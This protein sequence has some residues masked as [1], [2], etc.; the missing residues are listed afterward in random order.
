[1]QNLTEGFVDTAYPILSPLHWR[2]FAGFVVVTFLAV[3]IFHRN[4][5]GYPCPDG[6]GKNWGVES[7]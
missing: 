5:P 2:L 6:R 3:W 7:E 4:N 1:M